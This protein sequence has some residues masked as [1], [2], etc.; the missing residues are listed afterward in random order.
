MNPP[1]MYC[2]HAPHTHTT[3]LFPAE[4]LNMLTLSSSSRLVSET[5]FSRYLWTKM[6]WR[7]LR[8]LSAAV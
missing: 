2:T 4:P 6:K 8:A 5:T 7:D 1:T 3:A